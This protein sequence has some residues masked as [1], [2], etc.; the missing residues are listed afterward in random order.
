MTMTRAVEAT[1]FSDFWLSNNPPPPR[2]EGCIAPVWRRP[3]ISPY[4]G[5][6]DTGFCPLPGS[7]RL[8]TRTGQTYTDMYVL[9]GQFFRIR[10]SWWG[11]TWRSTAPNVKNSSHETLR[12]KRKKGPTSLGEWGE[13]FL[14]GRSKTSAVVMIDVSVLVILFSSVQSDG[15]FS[16]RLA[17]W[18]TAAPTS[19][20]H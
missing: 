1:V 2:S 13:G 4:E 20:T 6:F 8:F 10:V 19:R 14:R 5:K 3:P 9:W 16:R 7:R 11:W 15:N 18:M 17:K 12:W